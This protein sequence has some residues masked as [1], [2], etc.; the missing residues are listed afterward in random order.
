M[1][2]THHA[3]PA[4]V[5]A[6]SEDSRALWSWAQLHLATSLCELWAVP[7]Q[8]P[9]NGDV[10]ALETGGTKV[11]SLAS[12]L[13]CLRA[14]EP[15]HAE[16]VHCVAHTEQLAQVSLSVQETEISELLETMGFWSAASSLAGHGHAAGIL[17]LVPRLF[18]VQRRLSHEAV[19]CCQTRQ[20]LL[21]SVA[22]VSETCVVC[23]D[24]ADAS[25]ALLAPKGHSGWQALRSHADR[26]MLTSA[27]MQGTQA[28][29]GRPAGIAAA[30]GRAC[31]G[32]ASA[33]R[34]QGQPAERCAH[35]TA[36]CCSCSSACASAGEAPLSWPDGLVRTCLL[37]QTALRAC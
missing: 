24:A 26:T 23:A 16:D 15:C 28:A 2:S 5:E 32:G 7:G 37:T 36:D 27:C 35:R 11:R 19:R 30:D 3:I 10:Q 6:G 12:N 34:H 17:K 22:A 8:E 25:R 9:A 31:A 20:Q 18:S 29:A 1:Q 21:L 4:Q 14:A 33:G 13:L